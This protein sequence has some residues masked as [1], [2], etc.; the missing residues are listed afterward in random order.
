MQLVGIVKEVSEPFEVNG[1]VLR[2]V[3][4]RY[5]GCTHTNTAVFICSGIMAG[6]AGDFHEG[7][8]VRVYYD[9]VADSDKT[10]SR[11][12]TRG[13]EPEEVI[14]ASDDIE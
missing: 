6:I 3:F 11:V 1:V 12:K 4:V 13:I 14:L 8:R 10:H 5:R 9:L 2:R 7:Q